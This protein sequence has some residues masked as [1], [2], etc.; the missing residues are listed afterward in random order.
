MLVTENTGARK[1]ESEGETY[2]RLEWCKRNT[3]GPLPLLRQACPFV[4]PGPAFLRSSKKYH[5]DQA[6]LELPSCALFG[7]AQFVA[8]SVCHIGW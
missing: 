2:M 8:L 3:V 7:D 6:P 1:E 4:G 5:L